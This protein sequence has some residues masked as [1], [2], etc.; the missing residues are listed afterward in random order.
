MPGLWSK[1]LNVDLNILIRSVQPFWTNNAY[2]FFQATF[3]IWRP[4]HK[5]YGFHDHGAITILKPSTPV[6][7]I[8]NCSWCNFSHSCKPQV[9]INCCV[10]SLIYY[11]QM[12]NYYM[13]LCTYAPKLFKTVIPKKW[14]SSVMQQPDH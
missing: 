12:C 9:S 5:N 10:L 3:D 6:A 8:P 2:I 7:F 14:W 1:S 11:C 4:N 13:Q